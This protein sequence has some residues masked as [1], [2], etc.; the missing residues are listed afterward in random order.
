MEE[1]FKN[2]VFIRYLKGTTGGNK[3]LKMIWKPNKLTFTKKGPKIDET[4]YE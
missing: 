1:N 4:L 3:R 2:S